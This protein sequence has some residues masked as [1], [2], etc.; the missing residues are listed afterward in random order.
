MTRIENRLQLVSK[1]ALFLGVLGIGVSLGASLGLLELQQSC[2]AAGKL[3]SPGTSLLTVDLD[4]NACW[5]GARRMQLV[6]NVSVGVGSVL[7]L[8]G[9]VLDAYE[10]RV[11]EVAGW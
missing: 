6:A 4:E 9:G 2:V 5:D 7:A 1:L 11:R 3:P 8:G 10:E